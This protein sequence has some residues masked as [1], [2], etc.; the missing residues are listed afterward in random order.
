MY[1]IISILIF[2]IFIILSLLDAKDFIVASYNVQNLFDLTYDGTEYK[3]FQLNNKSHTKKN[4]DK[5]L[6]NI[7][8]VINDIDAD[9]IALQE[10]ES[11]KALELLSNKLPQYKYRIFYKNNKSS[12]GLS[13]LSKY[14]IVHS[15]FIKINHFNTYSRPLLKVTFKIDNLKFIIINNHWRSKKTK[16]N[17][18]IKYAIALKN[19]ILNFNENTDYILIGDF[20]ENYNEYKTF[21]YDRKLNNTYGITGINHIL[22]TVKEKLFIKKNNLQNINNIS[23]YNLWL[24]LNKLDRFSYRFRGNNN[25]PDNILIPYALI[26]NKKISYINNSFKVFKPPYL[27][28]KNRINRWR[29]NDGFSDHLPI[30]A[31]FSTTKKYH[32]K[33]NTVKIKQIN[34]ISTLYKL[35]T[36]IQPIKLHNIIVIYKDKDNAILKSK[37]NRAIY[38]Y[39]CATNLKIGG[40]YNLTVNQIENYNGLVEITKISNI[41]KISQNNKYSSY[42]YDGDKIDIFNLKY[43]N[44]IIYISKVTYK[45]NYIYLKNGLKI[46]IYFPKYLKKLKNNTTLKLISGHINIFKGKIQIFIH[47]KSDI[48]VIND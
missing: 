35:N 1:K 18:R 28:K 15:E 43:I 46:K 17:E 33:K 29:N 21:K 13:F 41:I 40:I 26:D 32:K 3:K 20:N 12:T 7:S 22:N 23:H 16:E 24:E 38:L 31:H 9:I 6:N 25:T 39:N 36:I 8:K 47:K 42:Y 34:K 48:K 44:D 2:K 45:K 27:F 10:I 30:M 19:Y 5:K 14:K 4:L 11:K 37:K